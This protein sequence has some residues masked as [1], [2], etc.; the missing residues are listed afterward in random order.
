MSCL[1]GMANDS[2]LLDL[3]SDYLLVAPAQVTCTELSRVLDG[4]LSHDRVQRW[5]NAPEMGSKDLWRWGKPLVRAMEKD[6][7]EEPVLIV[8]DRFQEKPHT[9]DWATNA[10]AQLAFL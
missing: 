6:L 5:L 1:Y 8:D 10:V 3:Y 9:D 2:F 7:D 4:K